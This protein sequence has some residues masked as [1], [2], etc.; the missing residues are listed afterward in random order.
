MIFKPFSGM[1]GLPGSN[2]YKKKDTAPIDLPHGWCG[3]S[4]LKIIVYEQIG[5]KHDIK[6][7]GQ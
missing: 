3:K 5:F 7:T 2:H 6:M 1:I 4:L